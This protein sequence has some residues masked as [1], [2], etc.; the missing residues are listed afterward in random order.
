VIAFGLNIFTRSVA[1]TVIGR[2][3]IKLWREKAYARKDVLTGLANRLEILQRLETEQGRS[4]RTKRPYSLLFI[5]IDQFKLINDNF[6][7]QVGDE[8]LSVLADIL[9]TSSR[10]I[11]VAT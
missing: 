1:F 7:H 8:V 10:K 9:R 5:D 3:L 11:D 4:E 6:G 2:V